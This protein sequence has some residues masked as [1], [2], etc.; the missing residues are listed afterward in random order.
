MEAL[1]VK[2]KQQE[3]IINEDALHRRKMELDLI[4]EKKK[5]Q[6]TLEDA[7]RGLK[8]SQE[9]VVDRTLIANLIVSYFQRKR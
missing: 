8:N 1:R 3:E 2:V 6:R 4:A 7:L 9:D 5:M